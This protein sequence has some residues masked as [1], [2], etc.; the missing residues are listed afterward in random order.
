MTHISLL[1]YFAAASIIVKAVMCLLLVASIYSWSLI[2][3]KG[4]HFSQL[5]RINNKFTE[6]F[7]SSLPLTTILQQYKEQVIPSSALAHVFLQGYQEFQR[8]FQA[9]SV[10]NAQQRE[11]II[12]AVMR[13]MNI[14]RAK[15]EQNLQRQLSWLATIGSISPYL[16]LFGTVWGIMASL[17]SLGSVQQATLSMV[18]PG[19]SEALVATA[20]GLFTAIPAS[21]A[22]NRLHQNATNIV[23]QYAI[24]QEE[25]C[26]LLE[27]ELLPT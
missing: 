1:H 4:R 18:A 17:Q 26:G 19:I 8:Y 5:R 3:H 23:E 22:Y 9:Q 24:F 2:F 20:M 15:E 7:W 6:S 21:I 12:M 11:H 25:F 14:V 10:L 16:G 27:H 13:A